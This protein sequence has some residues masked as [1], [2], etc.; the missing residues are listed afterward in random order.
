LTET[1]SKLADR[2]RG[3]EA[4]SRNYSPLYTSL[5]GIEASWFEAP[6]AMQDPLVIWLL[7]IGS[8]RSSLDISLLLNAGLHR[9]VLAGKATELA[10]YFPTAGGARGADDPELATIL[11]KTI[12]SCRHQ[13]TPFI[14]QANVQTNETGRGLCWLL[15][16]LST[17]WKSV[18][19][20]DLG[21][22]AGLN[23]VA[24]R[25]AYRLVDD[26]KEHVLLDVGGADS[27]QFQV[28]IRGNLP[29]L[30]RLRLGSLPQ[31]FSRTGFDVAPFILDSEVKRLTLMS[32][33]WGDQVSRMNRLREGIAALDGE[34]DSNAPVSLRGVDLPDELGTALKKHGPPA[35]GQPVIIYNTIMT[36]Y[37]KDKGSSLIRHIESWAMDQQRPVLWL[38]WEPMRD[39]QNSAAAG[40]FSWTADLWHQRNHYHWQLGWVHPHGV[41]FEFTDSFQ[42]WHEFCRQS[43]W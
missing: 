9:E 34:A 35:D 31:I 2:F 1:L 3:Q 25:R 24:D 12:L 15:P 6:Q 7:Q 21:A 38:Q 5:F 23:L 19:L 26:L 14:Q 37:L 39:S 17:G 40:R 10:L 20:L 43:S 36:M 13:L 28:R 41:E 16:L 4:F 30:D 32:F 42:L 22:S 33:I 11:R 8:E 29:E 27:V 18:H